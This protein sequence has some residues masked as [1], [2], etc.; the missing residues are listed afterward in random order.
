MNL[1][2]KIGLDQKPGA[3]PSPPPASEAR[4]TDSSE[5]RVTDDGETRV[6]DQ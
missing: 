5:D 2:L 6:I 3:A 4:V 1:G